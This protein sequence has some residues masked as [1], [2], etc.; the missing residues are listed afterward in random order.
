MI[1]FRC[2]AISFLLF[3]YG[4]VFVFDSIAIYMIAAG[5][6]KC[7]D[8]RYMKANYINT[9]CIVT[10]YSF[11]EKKCRSCD[12]SCISFIC[13]DEQFNVT[14]S[15]FNGSNITSTIKSIDQK[16][17]RQDKVR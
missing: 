12:D 16:S 6:N 10:E 15:I 13:Y 17:Q 11:K 2:F 5:A 14:Y 8:A 4:I 7:I 3:W 9:T 1:E